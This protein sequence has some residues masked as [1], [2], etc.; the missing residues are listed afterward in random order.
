MDGSHPVLLPPLIFILWLIVTA[1]M[2]V[3]LVTLLLRRKAPGQKPTRPPSPSPG[4]R[5]LSRSPQ[6]PASGEAEKTCLKIVLEAESSDLKLL[7]DLSAELSESLAG[8]TVKPH[9]R[10]LFNGISLAAAECRPDGPSRVTPETEVIVRTT[11]R[12][13]QMCCS[14]CGATFPG[15]RMICPS[16]R[17]SLPAIK[18]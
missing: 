14:A 7:N 18:L 5:I 2:L 17:V 11:S 4:E 13:V 8:R 16:C 15:V 3:T 9:D 12:P 6:P 1:V 10:L